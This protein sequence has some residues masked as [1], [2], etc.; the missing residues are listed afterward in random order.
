MLP[1]IPPQMP[2][3]TVRPYHSTGSSPKK[4]ESKTSTLRDK[5]ENGRTPLAPDVQILP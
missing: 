5:N 1:F 2:Q 4:K 3:S